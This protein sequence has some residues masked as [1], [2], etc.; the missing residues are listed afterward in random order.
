VKKTENIRIKVRFSYENSSM[1]VRNLWLILSNHQ[2]MEKEVNY[3]CKSCYYKITNIGL[4]R[5]YIN[6]EKCN[7]LVQH[8]ISRLKYGNTLL[9]NITLSLI[10]SVQRGQNCVPCLVTCAPKREHITPALFQ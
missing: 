3:T 10:N 9:Y 2:G 6:D 8:I 5:K 1:S 7:T 4:I